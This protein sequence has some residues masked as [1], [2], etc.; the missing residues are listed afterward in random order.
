MTGHPLRVGA[1]LLS[2]LL[3]AIFVVPASG[4]IEKRITTIH[5]KA[6]DG[7]PEGFGE[8]NYLQQ[9]SKIELLA[10]GTVT[11]ISAIFCQKL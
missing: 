7:G 9:G 6:Q 11:I 2:I 1:V 8:V 4:L 5:I 10:T 3:V